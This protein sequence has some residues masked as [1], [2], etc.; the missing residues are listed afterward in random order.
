MKL[1]QKPLYRPE[2][3]GLRALAVIPVIFYHAGFSPFSGGYVGVDVFFVISGYLITAIILSEIASG[4]FSTISFYERRA[5]RILPALFILLIVCLP[6]SWILMVP[7]EMKAFSDSLIAVSTFVSNLWFWRTT[8]YFDTTAHLKPLLHTWSLSVEEQFYIFYP[9]LLLLLSR[10]RKTVL[11][12]SL[13][14]TAVISL[15]LADWLSIHK[16]A[17]AFYLLPARMWELILGALAA[18]YLKDPP[19]WRLSRLVGNSGGFFGIA[20]LAYAIFMFDGQIRTPSYF[21]L[22]PTLGTICIILFV[23]KDSLLG[24]ILGHRILVGIGLLSY[25]AYLWHQ[26]TFAFARLSGLL[27]SNEMLFLPLIGAIFIIAYLSWK[28]V[29]SPFRDRRRFTR[30]TIIKLSAIFSAALIL[31]GLIGHFTSGF[32]YRYAAQDRALASLDGYEAGLYVSKRFDEKLLIPFNPLDGRRKVLII[33]D[34]FGQDLVNALHEGGLLLNMQISTKHISHLCG[35]LFLSE[36]E[37]PRQGVERIEQKCKG[38]GI[39]EDEGL[40]KLMLDA[41][42]IWF[43]SK[44]QAWQTVLIPQSIENVKKFSKKTVKVFGTKDF[45]RISL[46]ELLALP[47]NVRVNKIQKV[48]Q[49]VMKINAQIKQNLAPGEFIDSQKLVCFDEEASCRLFTEDGQLISFDGWHLTKDGARYFGLKLAN[50]PLVSRE[51]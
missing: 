18:I 2:I 25:S 8:N 32:L 46:K 4:T 29:E 34:S 41:D 30:K 51:R 11:I 33:G 12:L 7:V 9:I 10:F 19:E 6:F 27:E 36:K 42:E 17:A 38:I 24:K 16:T 31:F 47:S 15:I 5:R 50:E 23:T 13:S 39:Y 44:W 43:A 45:G 3:D 49:E 21:T 48:D 22:I 28:Y 1:L 40:K 14:I 35:N 20:L 26:P 37:F